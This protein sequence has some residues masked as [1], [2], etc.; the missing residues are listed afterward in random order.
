ML[1][2]RFSHAQFTFPSAADTGRREMVHGRKFLVN[3]FKHTDNR[4]KQLFSDTTGFFLISKL[5]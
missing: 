4:N 3:K 1:L 2:S 5:K